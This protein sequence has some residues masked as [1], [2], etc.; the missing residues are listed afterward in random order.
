VNA[1]AWIL[2]A[3]VGPSVLLTLVCAVGA[4]LMRDPFQAVHFISPPA[5]LSAFGIAAA[6]FFDGPGKQP[7][8]KAL[9]VAVVLTVMNG[10]ATHAT[11]RAAWVR[12]LGRWSSDPGKAD[13]VLKGATAPERWEDSA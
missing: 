7:G 9:V 13:E 4:A 5:T 2:L 10:V 12:V 11:A 1:H 6:A 8:G 3:L